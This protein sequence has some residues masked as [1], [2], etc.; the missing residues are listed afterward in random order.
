MSIGSLEFAG[1]CQLEA[2][3]DMYVCQEVEKGTTPIDEHQLLCARPQRLEAVLPLPSDVQKLKLNHHRRD[4][5]NK[6]VW[7]E[8]TGV[9]HT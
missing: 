5:Q 9:A 7:R 6:P 8:L 2:Q 1:S 3:A 4:A